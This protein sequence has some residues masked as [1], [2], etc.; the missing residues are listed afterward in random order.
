MTIVHHNGKCRPTLRQFRANRAYGWEPHRIVSICR[1]VSE[2]RSRPGNLPCSLSFGSRIPMQSKRRF[3]SR[4]QPVSSARQPDPRN[5]QP[6]G[7]RP[8]SVMPQTARAPILL[9]AKFA[10]C[11]CADFQ[12]AARVLVAVIRCDSSTLSRGFDPSLV[13]R[14]SGSSRIRLLPR[15]CRAR[16]RAPERAQRPREPNSRLSRGSF[17]TSRATRARRSGRQLRAPNHARTRAHSARVRRNESHF[18]YALELQRQR[19]FCSRC[20]RWSCTSAALPY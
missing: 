18:A 1:A 19:R 13:R 7:S 16:L 14:F 6:A 5:Q 9:V 2:Q 17:R 15:S 20:S 11:C 3:Q 10:C 12:R 4:S 8:V